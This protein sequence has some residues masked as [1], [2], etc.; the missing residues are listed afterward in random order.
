[1]KDLER[2]LHALMILALDGDAAAYAELLGR[3]ARVL[4]SYLKKATR[5]SAPAEQIEDLIQ[6][7]LLAIHQKRSTYQPER[8]LMPWVFT[9]AR[10][11]LIDGYRARGR[12]VLTIPLDTHP[13]L[14]ELT[15]DVSDPVATKMDLE[16]ILEKLSPKQREI[17]ELAKVDGVPLAEIGQAKNMSLSAVK[18]TIHRALAMLK[19]NQKRERPKK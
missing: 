7:V 3:L 6:D 16:T 11:K 14:E 9:I 17:L 8:A 10:Y 15:R 13:D 4:R 5:A 18:V 1:M 19:A 2:E 12:E